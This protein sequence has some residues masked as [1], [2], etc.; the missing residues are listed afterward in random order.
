VTQEEFEREWCAGSG[1]TVEQARAQGF[2][3]E[4]CPPDCGYEGCQGWRMVHDVEREARRIVD[5]MRAELQAFE[6]RVSHAM[7][8]PELR[9]A[10]DDVAADLAPLALIALDLAQLVAP[11]AP[12]SEL[13]EAL[14]GRT[15][16]RSETPPR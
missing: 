9:A 1:R 5:A 12:T 10:A 8:L 2:S 16:V 13:Q 11:K 7:R 14:H 3:P 15:R 6:R 4:R